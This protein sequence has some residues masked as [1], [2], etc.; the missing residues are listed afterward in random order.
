MWPLSKHASCNSIICTAHTWLVLLQSAGLTMDGI[1]H[2]P[3]QLLHPLSRG[4]FNELNLCW[5]SLPHLA[6]DHIIPTVLIS[7]QHVSWDKKRKRKWNR[8]KSSNHARFGLWLNIEGHP[9]RKNWVRPTSVLRVGRISR[10]PLLVI[11]HWP[12]PTA[13]R[14]PLGLN[15]TLLAWKRDFDHYFGHG[16]IQDGCLMPRFHAKE[17]D[18]MQRQGGRGRG[19]GLWLAAWTSFRIS[20]SLLIRSCWFMF[21]TDPLGLLWWRPLTGYAPILLP[22]RKSEC[23]K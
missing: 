8:A 16:Q 7:Q 19:E 3:R 17:R 4:T 18:K 21:R 14:P 1:T 22:P 6:P 11:V 23:I 20:R 10:E 15:W 5:A 13:R 2:N 9:L 12:L